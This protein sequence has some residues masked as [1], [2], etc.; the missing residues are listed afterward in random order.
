M[1]ANEHIAIEKNCILITSNCIGIYQFDNLEHKMDEF[2]FNSI[3]SNNKNY[4]IRNNNN[5]EYRC[6]LEQD[7]Y[8][9]NSY[10]F[11]VNLEKYD[12]AKGLFLECVNDYIENKNKEVLILIERKQNLLLSL[13]VSTKKTSLSEE[14]NNDQ[15]QPQRAI[16]NHLIR[17]SQETKFTQKE[18]YQMVI[19]SAQHELNM[20]EEEEKY[21]FKKIPTFKSIKEEIAK[22]KN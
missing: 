13:G 17:E 14:I 3:L 11:I 16:S 5:R 21:I 6:R 22:R 4:L 12:E 10:C 2:E 19:D 1:R 20:I 15:E 7:Y 9:D 18:F 8:F